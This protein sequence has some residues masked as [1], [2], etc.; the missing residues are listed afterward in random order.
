MNAR[1]MVFSKKI[2]YRRPSNFREHASQGTRSVFLPEKKKFKISPIILTIFST[3]LL[4]GCA[5][6]VSNSGT[7]VSVGTL[8]EV[9]VDD[10]GMVSWDNA[11]PV[12]QEQYTGYTLAGENLSE[13]PFTDIISAEGNQQDDVQIAIRGMVEENENPIAALIGATTNE[14]TMRASSLVNFFNVPMIVPT[15]NGDNLL[16]SN[17]LWAFRLSAPGSAYA[18]YLF[19]T[20]LIK[21]EFGSDPE[22]TGEVS[23]LNI[24]ILYE[25]NTFGESAAVATVRAAM[26]LGVGVDVYASFPPET[27]DS[28]TLN[29]LL[30]RVV[31]EG[32]HLIYLVSSDPGVAK[33]LVQLLQSGIPN[34]A[35]PV[36]VGQAGGFAS[37][38][39]SIPR[40]QKGYISSGSRSYRKTAR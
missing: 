4:A 34:Y 38:D 35:M 7:D 13:Y 18:K 14:A 3:I 21:S 30:N 28:A 19:G 26:E 24:A 12:A 33:T 32:V 40:R 39:L 25:G 27:P 8:W 31:E 23:K 2:K 10:R 5:R 17:N 9:P 36:L 20:L 29:I 1:G 22:V 15:A 16:P 6:S 37:Q 11:S